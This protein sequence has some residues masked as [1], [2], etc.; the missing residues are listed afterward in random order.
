MSNSFRQQLFSGEGI[1]DVIDFR[2]AALIKAVDQ[3]P[4][5]VLFDDH[6]KVLN[7]LVPE[8]I[9]DVPVLDLQ[10]VERAEREVAMGHDGDRG[11]EIS[12]HVPFKGDRGLLLVRPS[13][14]NYSFPLAEVEHAALVIRVARSDHNMAEY[15]RA[16]DQTIRVIEAALSQLRIDCK[17][18]RSQLA[19]V[20]ESHLARRRE[21]RQKDR[22][23]LDQLGG[24]KAK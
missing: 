20:A 16:F 9:I 7:S 23:L 19:Q 22:S 2:R 17:D 18:V 5:S 10:G 15:Q 4:D 1:R 13:C 3:L 11:T 8:A 24:S 14:Y 12:F 6:A 21:K